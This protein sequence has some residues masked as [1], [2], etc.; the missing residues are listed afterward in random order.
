MDTGLYIAIFQLAEP[1]TIRVGRLGRFQFPAGMYFYVGSAQRGLSARLAR[2]GRPNKPRHWHIDYLTAH[3]AM[4]GHVTIPG[5]KD[6]ECK[7]AADLAQHFDRPVPRF[8]ASDCR[9][10][11]H[12]FHTQP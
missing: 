2:H 6:A 12:L 5:R 1:R 7:V 9:C 4:I 11:G 3:A 8:G 10:Q